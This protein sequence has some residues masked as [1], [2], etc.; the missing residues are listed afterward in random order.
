MTNRW[1]VLIVE[2]APT[3][4]AH[5]F[6]AI[7]ANVLSARTAGEAI[8][9]CTEQAVDLIVVD[10][11]L[12]G[13]SGLAVIQHITGQ[14][15]SL[16][17]TQTIVRAKDARHRIEA[18]DLGADDAVDPTVSEEELL[19]R[20]RRAQ[21]S[22]KTFSTLVA[23]NARL[24]ELSLT[25]GLTQV[26]NRQAFQERLRD[27][28]RRSQRYD[29]PLALILL[30]LDHFK[31]INDQFGH[32]VGDQVLRHLA[33]VLKL[34]VR[35][36]DFVARFGG[37][38]FAVLLP[39]TH[40]AGALTVAERTSHDI[41]RIH[42]SALKQMR[43]TASFGISCFPTRAIGSMEQLVKAADDAMYRAKNEGRNKISLHQPALL[44]V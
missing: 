5:A 18:L 28:F 17:R 33:E 24:R 34:A 2:D 3:A 40:L 12:P 39:K 27:E 8:G 43:V 25:D 9:L 30:D 15:A 20:A 1:T 37:E 14:G 10:R 38:E 22:A 21:S 32:P 44:A 42:L 29:D 7:N 26:A 11:D 4:A 6:A 41:H 35:E 31:M 23:D 16:R 19:S 36:T 13:E